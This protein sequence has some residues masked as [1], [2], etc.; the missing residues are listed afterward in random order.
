MIAKHYPLLH[1]EVV[2][3]EKNLAIEKVSKYVRAMAFL[4]SNSHVLAVPGVGS[5]IARHNVSWKVL[6][7]IM[8]D[9]YRL[10]FAHGGNSDFGLVGLATAKPC[11]NTREK[12]GN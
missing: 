11:I 7:W 2:A 6:T 3:L 1:I 9:L 10:Q 4:V 12:T 5:L 8:A